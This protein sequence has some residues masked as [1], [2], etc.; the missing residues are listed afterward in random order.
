MQDQ[1]GKNAWIFDIDGV[2]TNPEEKRVPSNLINYI[3]RLIERDNFVAFVTGRSLGWTRT[4]V[5]NKLKL[6]AQRKVFLSVEKGGVWSNFEYG[7]WTVNTDK[8]ISPP[9]SFK[10]EVKDLV[11]SQF[12]NIAFFDPKETM[13]S[14]EMHDGMRIED[15]EKPQK[16]LNQILNRL[17]A[18]NH[19][20]RNFVLDW[21]HI[22]SDIQNK[23]AG[24]G[25]GTQRVLSYLVNINIKPRA[26]IAFGDSARDVEIAEEINKSGKPVKFIF[27]GPEKLLKG[28]K[29]PF[30]IIFYG[31]QY[32]QGTLQFLRAA[33]LD[34][35]N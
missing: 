14:I 23:M 17:L 2:L 18:G 20:Q 16:K 8:S 5:V 13:I 10:S 25:L 9:Q 28:K 35:K 34:T 33:I 21:G 24:K 3:S 15:F 29:F 22:A 19:L 6:N 27:T 7:K 30:E 32:E 11:N 1:L 12:S 31:G 26:F 4:R